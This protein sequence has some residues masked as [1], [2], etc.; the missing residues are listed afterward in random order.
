MYHRGAVCVEQFTQY[1]RAVKNHGGNGAQ[2][3]LDPLRAWPEEVQGG[4]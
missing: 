3:D 2:C 4:G 1:R